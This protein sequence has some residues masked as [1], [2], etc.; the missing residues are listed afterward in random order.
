MQRERARTLHVSNLLLVKVPDAVLLVVHLHL[1][2][3]EDPML[4]GVVD[5]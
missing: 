2:L 5:V 3:P 4:A 1:E